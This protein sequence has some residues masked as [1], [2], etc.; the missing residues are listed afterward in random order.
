MLFPILL[1]LGVAVLGFALRTFQHPIFQKLGALAI[2]ATSFLLGW[3]L[4]G[5]VAAGVACSLSWFFLPWLEILTRIR[6]LRLPLEK[7]LRPKSPPSRDD[8]PWLDELTQE[9][10]DEGFLHLDDTGWDWDDCQ[11]FFRLFYKSEDRSQSAI[12]LVDQDGMGF[13][14]LSVSSRAKD[15]TV[16]TTWNYPFSNSLKRVPRLKINRVRGSQSFLQLHASHRAFLL[17]NQV[18]T[19]QLVELDPDAIPLDIQN[20]L[21]AQIAHNL[22]KGV[23]TPA[24]EGHIRYSWRGLVYIWF[25]FL[26][27]LVRF[28]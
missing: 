23:L 4:T 24:G 28:T 5:H 17:K 2:L 1:T 10:E 9:I 14:Y 16:W 22:N 8:F 13:Y 26:R 15:G 19:E 27:D 11:Q 7:K 21:R 25:Q 6:K 20:D 12:C 18:T 3:F